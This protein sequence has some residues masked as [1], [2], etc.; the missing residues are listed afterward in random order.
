[1]M[2]G[3]FATGQANAFGPDVKKAHSAAEKIFTITQTPSEIDVLA[4]E[5]K[6]VQE[7]SDSKKKSSHVNA[8]REPEAIADKAAPAKDKAETEIAKLEHQCKNI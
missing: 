8:E 7:V 1:M 3:T 5:L 2:F 6:P 4:E